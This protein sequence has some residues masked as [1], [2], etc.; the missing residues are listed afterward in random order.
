MF[1]AVVDLIPNVPVLCASLFRTLSPNSGKGTDHGWSGHSFIVG[2]DVN[3]GRILGEYPD[4]LSSSSPLNIGRGRLI[5]TLPWEA[6]WNGVSQWLGVDDVESL[7]KILPNR[8]SFPEEKLFEDSDLY[9]QRDTTERICED[10]G[11]IITCIPEDWD[12]NNG[13]EGD[14]WDGNNGDDWEDR[15]D[16]WNESRGENNGERL[17]SNKG[18]TVAAVVV[19]PL[20]SILIAIAIAAVFNKRTGYFTACYDR[21]LLSWPDRI[22]KWNGSE[23]GDTSHFS[24]DTF[25]LLHQKDGEGVEIAHSSSI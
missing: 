20:V 2:G 24:G 7:N 9:T 8:L 25:T 10:E 1:F 6:V 5:P 14:D 16:D 15:D 13:D 21:C 12:G 23:F 4:D 22:T 19:V 11:E 18:G 3:G 17:V